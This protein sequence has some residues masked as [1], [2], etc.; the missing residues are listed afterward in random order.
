MCLKDNDRGKVRNDEAERNDEVVKKEHAQ[1]VLQ[2]CH[3]WKPVAVE[4]IDHNIPGNI[5]GAETKT[6]HG[7]TQVINAAQVFRVQKNGGHANFGAKTAYDNNH[8]EYPEEKKKL[9][10]F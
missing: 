8:Q 4:D 7:K 3:E 10:P 6:H 9:M 5:E 2:T 1:G